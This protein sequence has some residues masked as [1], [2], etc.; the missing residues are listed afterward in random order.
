MK[1]MKPNMDYNITGAYKTTTKYGEKI[2]LK[3]D[4]AILY[5][6]TRFLTLGDDAI[7]E[8]SEGAYAICKIPL[9]EGVENPLYKLELK[10][11]SPQPFYSPYLE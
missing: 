6:P 9:R 7:K 10:Q 5:L 3:L 8:L 1:D 2:V 4:D 11:L